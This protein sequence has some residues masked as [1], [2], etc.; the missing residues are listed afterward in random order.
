MSYLF[1]HHFQSLG[2]NQK[3]CELLYDVLAKHRDPVVVTR[4]RENEPR[5]RWTDAVTQP[6]HLCV[7]RKLRQG[8]ADQIRK[9][10]EFAIIPIKNSKLGTTYRVITELRAELL[11]KGLEGRRCMNKIK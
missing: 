11:D 9:E 2:I 10:P 5:F 6:R 1:L 4:Q 7:K 3:T 8:V